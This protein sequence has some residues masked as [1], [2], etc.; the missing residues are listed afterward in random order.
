MNASQFDKC[1]QESITNIKQVLA[2]K[3]QEYAHGDRLS[4]FKRAAQMNQCTPEKALVGM[5]SKHII[6][7]LDL[8]DEIE[9]G[10]YRRPNLRELIN[11][12]VGDNINYLILLRALVIERID[13]QAKERK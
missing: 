8:V 1:V 6:S 12:K 7:V 3:A 4:N 2:A 9:S 10:L 5:M 13:T 11:E